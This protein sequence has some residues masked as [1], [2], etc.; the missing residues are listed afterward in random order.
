MISI[1]SSF[2]LYYFVIKPFFTFRNI[3]TPYFNTR[4]L[5]PYPIADH[6]VQMPV[7]K[8]NGVPGLHNGAPNSLM[9]AN[10]WAMMGQSNGMN[11]Y[12]LCEI[13]HTLYRL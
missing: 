7:T 5:D 4:N 3:I 11:G 9:A 2:G 10:F 1:I 6:S 12:Y 8:A 13:Y